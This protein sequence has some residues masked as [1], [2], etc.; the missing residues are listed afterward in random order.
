[1][2]KSTPPYKIEYTADT[3]AEY[4]LDLLEEKD[5]E[6]YEIPASFLTSLADYLDDVLVWSLKQGLSSNNY[7]SY[8]GK[9]PRFKILQYLGALMSVIKNSDIKLKIFIHLL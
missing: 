6:Y 4:L 9:V 5:E 8:E 3:F 2:N 7:L 1:M